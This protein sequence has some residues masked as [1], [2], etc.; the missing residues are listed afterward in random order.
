MM[1]RVLWGVCVGLVLLVVPTE[2]WAQTPVK[3]PSGVAFLCPDHATDDGHEVDIIR[4]SDGVVIQT[5]TVGDPPLNTAGEV[6]VAINVQPIAK[7]LYRFAVR[8]REGTS[9]SD[10]S[11][12]SPIWDRAPGRPTDVIGR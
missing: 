3:N 12:P 11:L 6:E 8:A 9:I 4:E 2:L 10:T 1:A 5:L 7:G